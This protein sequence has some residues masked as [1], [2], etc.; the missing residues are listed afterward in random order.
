MGRFSDFIRN[1]PDDE[2]ERVY[3]NVIDRAIERQRGLF[4]VG[5]SYGVWRTDEAA[6]TVTVA[7]V[8]GRKLVL[9]DGRT[10]TILDGAAPDGSYEQ[11]IRLNEIGSCADVV[12]ACHHKPTTQ[13]GDGGRDG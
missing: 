6:E 13:N 10:A 2:R 8:S 1:A 7:S 4:V 12:R 9:A 3:G 11:V 5:E